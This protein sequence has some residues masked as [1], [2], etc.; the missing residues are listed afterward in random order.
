MSYLGQLQLSAAGPSGVI[1][2]PK[3]IPISPVS[4]WGDVVLDAQQASGVA[5]TFDVFTRLDAAKANLRAIGVGPVGCAVVVRM[6]YAGT[7]TTPP[8][9]WAIGLDGSHLRPTGAAVTP[10]L[11]RLKDSNGNAVIQIV[12]DASDLVDTESNKYT[13][14]ITIDARAN[15]TVAIL[16][17]IAES[18]A[19]SSAIE[20]KVI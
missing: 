15:T 3:S 11:Q 17:E 13:A 2:A 8:T 19:T 7:V 4:N 12:T 9:I 10:R 14:A 6:R 16:V 1:D 5:G 18:G 20:A